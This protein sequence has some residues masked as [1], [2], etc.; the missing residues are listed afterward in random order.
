MSTATIGRP[1]PK[2]PAVLGKTEPRHFTAPLD[3]NCGPCDCQV[4]QEIPRNEHAPDIKPC[5]THGYRAIFFA[6]DL[7]HLKLYPWQEWLL[8]HALELIEEDNGIEVYRFRIV[9]VECARQNG[10]TVVMVILALWNMFRQ[11]DPDVPESRTIIGTAQDLSKADDSWRYAVELAE[12]DEELYEFVDPN[13]ILFGH[14]KSFTLTTGS[15]YRVASTTGDAGRG[16]SGDVILMDELRT[17]KDFASWSAVT[18]TMNARPKG[19][20]W[21]FSNAGDLKAVV[22]RYQ[23]ALAHRDL[24]WPDGEEEFEGVLDDIDEDLQALL[25]AMPDL[26]PGW[27]EWSA[28]PE[29]PRTDLEALSQANPSMNHVAVSHNCPTTRTLLFAVASSPAYEVETE[30]MCR[31]AT[32]GVGG[33]FP[34]DSW[35]NTIV[36]EA[37]KDK[38]LPAEDTKRVLCVE[39]S[40]RRSQTHITRASLTDDGTVLVSMRHDNPGTDWV[41]ECL[42][43]ERDITDLVVVR[44]EAGSP[45]LTLFEEL[46][47]ELVNVDILEWKG[48]DIETAFGQI[49]DRL[50]DGKIRHAS[51]IPLDTAAT[52]AIPIIKPGGGF[53]V[54]IKRSPSDTAPLYACVGAVWGLEKLIADDYDIMGSVL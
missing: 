2:Q 15:Q 44:T 24:G 50:R 13:Q 18:N 37:D 26:K 7:L 25:D 5:R 6:T 35:A 53:R 23:R 32:M 28:P 17:H 54:D 14:P 4:C 11:D 49:F 36:H 9:I 1:R 43:E 22:L 51:N 46:Q 27:F 10:K 39:V 47:N 42:V 30:V 41:V 45:T 12:A 31:W 16:F 21:A 40:S 19:Q 29:V 8:I 20:A 3:E 38:W 52:S 34:E 48:A 33:P